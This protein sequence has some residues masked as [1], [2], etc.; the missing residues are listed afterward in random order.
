MPNQFKL[1]SYFCNDERIKIYKQFTESLGKAN[2]ATKGKIKGKKKF[3]IIRFR[4]EKRALNG[5]K[6]KL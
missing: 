2:R 5:H 4:R 1:L 6:S 3:G